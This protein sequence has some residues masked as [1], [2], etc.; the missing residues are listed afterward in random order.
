[1]SERLMRMDSIAAREMAEYASSIRGRTGDPEYLLA[2]VDEDT[3]WYRIRRKKTHDP[4][5]NAH[6]AVSPVST[7]SI[8]QRPAVTSIQIQASGMLSPESLARYDAV[9]WS[10]S[11]VEK[12]VLPYYAS[13]YQWAAAHVLQ[14]LSRVFY[15]E[16]PDFRS[17]LGPAERGEA[18]GVTEDL[19][20]P[21]PGLPFALA[22]L[23][24]S[25]YVPLEA[26]S[27]PGSSLVILFYDPVSAEVA[28]RSLSDYL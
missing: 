3:G 14:R 5:S 25:D 20:L 17:G 22:H 19:R 2:S 28:H 8:A 15:G 1:M 21:D 4:C 13:K 12:F 9:F 7:S 16:V 23:P 11:A 24:R 27:T 6:E 18:S 10:E 26:E